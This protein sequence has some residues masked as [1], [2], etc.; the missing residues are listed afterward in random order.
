MMDWKRILDWLPGGPHWSAPRVRSTRVL[1]LVFCLVPL[2]G[3][4]SI[5]WTADA[6]VAWSAG[7]TSHSA[8]ARVPSGSLVTSTE[9]S[10]I[11]VDFGRGGFVILV[12]GSRAAL[13]RIDAGPIQGEVTLQAGHVLVD[14]PEHAPV[15]VKV[16]AH[17][18]SLGMLAV[19]GQTLISVDTNERLFNAF[20]VRGRTAVD[21]G[22]P[23]NVILNAV[24]GVLIL[25]DGRRVDNAPD[26]ED[27]AQ[28][29]VALLPPPAQLEAPPSGGRGVAEAPAAARRPPGAARRAVPP[30]APGSPRPT[31]CPARVEVPTAWA[32]PQVEE[33]IYR[34][35]SE[36]MPV[37]PGVMAFRYDEYGRAMTLE[38]VGVEDPPTDAPYGPYEYIWRY[39]RDLRSEAHGTLFEYVSAHLCSGRTPDP[40]PRPSPPTPAPTVAVGSPRIPDVRYQGRQGDGKRWH[41]G[42]GGLDVDECDQACRWDRRCGFWS[43]TPGYFDLPLPGAKKIWIAPQ[44]TLRDSTPP[45]WTPDGKHQLLIPSPG[46][47]VRTV[48]TGEHDDPSPGGARTLLLSP[49]IRRNSE[50]ELTYLPRIQG[51]SSTGGPS[52]ISDSV[53]HHHCPPGG[54]SPEDCQTLCK[55]NPLCA[56]WVR[57]AGTRPGGVGAYQVKSG[58]PPYCKLY[59][60]FSGFRPKPEEEKALGG[61]R[62][63]TVAG[64][65]RR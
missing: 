35:L 59:A 42:V 63:P 62:L 5:G 34:W 19:Q 45:E 3:M 40:A 49:E 12:D 32:D 2:L 33:L 20:A 47:F 6:T 48:S 51:R 52:R 57:T 21:N 24:G 37:I 31:A 58:L 54:C 13:T 30:P 18:R 41:V 14:A 27:L 44:C 11:R 39:A 53:I 17:G 50:L 9:D 38:N 56:A 22:F 15:I 65:T 28:I 10:R 7:Q 46:A 55:E 16:V 1:G 60:S 8:G 43:W 61:S 29:A 4:T 23:P 64:R 25:P 36:S 26:A